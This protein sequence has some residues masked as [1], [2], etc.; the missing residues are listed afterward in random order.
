MAIVLGFVGVK[1]LAQGAG[2]ELSTALSLGIV[3][4]VLGV[5]IGMS[6]YEN[7]GDKSRVPE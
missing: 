6:V 2:F 4:A 1:L 3:T 5:G 7:N